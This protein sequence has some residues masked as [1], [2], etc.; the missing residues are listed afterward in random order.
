MS[1]NPINGVRLEAAEYQEEAQL[2]QEAQLQKGEAPGIVIPV[3]R[4]N[5]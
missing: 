3:W 2:Q 1:N 4:T 5:D